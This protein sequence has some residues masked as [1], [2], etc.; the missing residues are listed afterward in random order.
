[1]RSKTHFSIGLVVLATFLIVVAPGSPVLAVTTYT[2]TD[3]GLVRGADGGFTPQ[4]INNKGQIAGDYQVG[5]RGD[6]EYVHYAALWDSGE[7]TELSGLAAPYSSA[8]AI[9][10]L[11][12][13]VGFTGD[14]YYDSPVF[15]WQDGESTYLDSLSEGWVWDAAI[16]NAGQIV[17]TSDT[18]SRDKWDNGLVRAVLWED[19]RLTD[20]GGLGDKLSS[21]AV[22]INNLGQIA[23]TVHGGKLKEGGLGHYPARH[24]AL[25]TD[26]EMR[27]L[28]AFKGTSFN[29]AVDINDVGQVLCFGESVGEPSYTYLWEDGERTEIGTLP[30]SLNENEVFAI[31]NSGHVVG[32]A[33]SEFIVWA[34]VLTGV[35]SPVGS[36]DPVAEAGIS[37]AFLWE[38]G[39]I[40]DLDDLIPAD[41][42][43]Q[44]S[45]AR[46]INDHGQIIGTG[47][48]DGELHGFLLTP[49]EGTNA[50]ALGYQAEAAKGMK[51]VMSALDSLSCPLLTILLSALA[52]V[53]FGLLGLSRAAP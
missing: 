14:N 37:R 22:A 8:A 48:F 36:F 30:G 45:S 35:I 47:V 3:L 4:A 10:D 2:I 23:G 7:I 5:F 33:R 53:G 40:W 31:N 41:S 13:V 34:S 43:W 46:D 27:D 32:E 17:G 6:A 51:P 19:G 18:T 39:S 12:Q 16:N 26:G 11:G 21:R 28:G 29:H 50:D 25:W 42:G 49:V 52:C 20:L 15:V 1:M 38:N 44:L 9:N 24:V